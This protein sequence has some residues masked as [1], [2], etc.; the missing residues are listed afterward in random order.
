VSVC[1]VVLCL[2]R[3]KLTSLRM[4]AIKVQVCITSSLESWQAR[5]KCGIR[6]SDSYSGLFSSWQKG[7]EVR[8]S[9]VR[10]CVCV[11]VFV[12]ACVRVWYVVRV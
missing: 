12:F 10:V 11:C 2:N 7:Q 1:V 6:V 3:Y 8:E 4:K 5:Y 9:R